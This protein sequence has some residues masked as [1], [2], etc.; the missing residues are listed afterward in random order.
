M[1]D[2]LTINGMLEKQ[3]TTLEANLNRRLDATETS[4]NRRF[5]QQ[6]RALAAI[7]AQTTATNGRVTALERARERGIGVVFAFKWAPPVLTAMVT[8]GLTILMMALTGAIR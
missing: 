2:E 4:V 1:A 7:Q 5:D 8:A 6:D 3:I